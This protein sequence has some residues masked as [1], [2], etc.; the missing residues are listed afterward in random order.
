M[1]SNPPWMNSLCSQNHATATAI[2][3]YGF[4]LENPKIQKI[5]ALVHS[6]YLDI[7]DGSGAKNFTGQ[8]IY[9]Y[10]PYVKFSASYSL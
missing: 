1:V 3:Y 10:V 7:G 8:R 2:E 9:F 4:M 6:L 5:V